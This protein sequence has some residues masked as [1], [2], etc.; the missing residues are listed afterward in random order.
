MAFLTDRPID[1]APLIAPG[2][3]RRSRRHRL[4]SGLGAESPWRT[5]GVCASSTRPM[6]RWSKPSALAS[7]PRRKPAGRWPLPCG[8]VSARWR[9]AMPPW[10]SRSAW[11]HRDEAF[12]ACRYVIEELKRRV[13]IWKRE[14][15]EDGTV[16]WVDPTRA[17]EDRR[18]C[19]R[20][21][22]PDRAPDRSIST[23]RSEASA[24]PSPIAATCAAATACRRR[25]TSG[26]PARRSSPSRRSI[27]WRESSSGSASRSSG[28]P[29]ASRCC[30]TICRRWS[31]ALAAQR[32]RGG[33]RPHH[34]R[35]PA[36]PEA[37]ALRAAGLQRVT[38]SLDTLQPQRMAEFARSTRHADVLA[39]I[40]AALAAGFRSV[41]LN[42]VVI[43][44]Y[45]DD[46]IGDLLEFARARGVE[47]RFIEYMDVGGATDWS[48]E[49]VVS[50]ARDS[51]DD[52][53]AVRAGASRSSESIVGAR[54]AVLPG[55]WN[56]FGVIASTTA[57]FC[58]T[59]DRGRLTADGTFLLCLYGESGLDLREPLRPALTDDGDRRRSIASAWTAR[60]DRGAE[61]RA[62]TARARH[63]PPDR[64][65]PRRSPARDAHPGRLMALH[66]ALIQPQIPPNTGNIARLCAATDT[67]L[68][69]IEPLG[70][71]IDDAD[72]RR[73]GLDYWD[74]VDL[75]VH[76]DW[77]AFRDAMR[78]E[79]L[80]LL[81]GQ[82]RADASGT[83]PF[84]RTAAWCSATRPRACRL[85][86]LEK[87]PER[88]FTIPMTGPVRS[89]NLATAVGIVLYEALRQPRGTAAPTP[90]RPAPEPTLYQTHP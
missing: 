2:A 60:T 3:V 81:L 62:A 74:S 69:L 65:P 31:S 38:V 83:P 27:G 24:S 18:R 71:S 8:I 47:A 54:R 35:H 36:G 46:E 23:G 19:P 11:A 79:P 34:Q 33:S 28:S 17:S 90:R 72:V 56:R 42:T 10:R 9:S 61:Q 43:R 5:R 59:C 45:N 20:D 6:D 55:R 1:L 13:P 84:S 21:R 7:W 12:V 15:Y 64:E 37:A 78:P 85:R 30:A 73:A 48:M 32:G 67:S 39:G 22:L 4:F 58:R 50:Q 49:Q 89:L 76:P 52:R 14:S 88:C 41:K 40:A 29:G 68:H 44:G 26:C 82:G 63:S 16:E 70:F 51:G 66:V 53:R 80:S 75:W 77:F 25:N 86:I 57:P 87:H